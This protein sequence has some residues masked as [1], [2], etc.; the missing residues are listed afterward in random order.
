MDPF[1]AD[2]LVLAYALV[3]AVVALLVVRF[4]DLYEREPISILA[5]LFLWGAVVAAILA[6]AGNAALSD[7]LPRDVEVVFGPMISAPIV[8]ELAK[9][10]ALVVAFLASRWANRR[11]GVF[12]FDGITDGIVYGAAVG[13]GFAFTEDLYYFFREAR[14]AGVAEALDVFVD[15]RDFLG[16]AMLRHAIWTATFGAGL[17]A[18]TRA[19]S[20]KGKLGW[21]VLGLAAAMLMHAIN[22]GLQPVLLS[23]KY[24]FETTYD[25]FA[26]GVPVE[27]ADRMDASARSITDTLDWISLAYVFAFFGLIALGL[28]HQRRVIRTQLEPEVEN[29]LVSAEQ[30]AMAGSFRR[31]VRTEAVQAWRGDLEAAR[32]T[33]V[34]CRELAELAFAKDRLAGIEDPRNQVDAHRERVH[35]LVADE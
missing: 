6:S 22:N 34:L 32:T 20:W 12:E 18:A 23:I 30:A 26:V 25:Y 29:G 4:L 35:D 15:R 28:R 11:F 8:E 16:P 5:L 31:R 14:V 17:G 21:P 7:E 13:I 19:R 3:Q 24:G 27:L 2:D 10:L 33:S 9:G 1:A